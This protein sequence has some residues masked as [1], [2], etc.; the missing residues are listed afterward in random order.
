MP[1][2]A[3]LAADSTAQTLPKFCPNCGLEFKEDYD[4]FCGGCA[5][6]RDG[7]GRPEGCGDE[8]Q[9]CHALLICPRDRSCA[10]CGATAPS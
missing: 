5:K 6:R 1:R 10:R 4:I 2:T 7:L 9:R 8:C 3:K